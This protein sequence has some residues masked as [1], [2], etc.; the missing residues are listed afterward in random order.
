[1]LDFS[2]SP[3]YEP[4]ETVY[5]SSQVNPIVYAEWADDPVGFIQHLGYELTDEQLQIAYSVQ[6][7]RVT[8][9]QAAHGVGKTFLAALLLVWWVI[10]VRGEAI[11]TAP[12][13]RQVKELLWKEVNKAVINNGLPDENLGRVHYYLDESA[14]AIGFTANDNNSNAFQ[15]VHAARLLIIED[16][17]CGISNEI[18]DGAVSCATGAQNRI[19]R[20]GNPI[21]PNNAFHRACMLGH[22]RV[23]VWSHP[24]IAWAYEK[25]KEDGI[26]RLK[27]EVRAEIVNPDGTLV[28]QEDW[29]EE[30]PR[31]VVP[32]AISVFYVEE[33]A[34]PRGEKSAFWLGRV[35]GLFPEDASMA[36][37]P[38]SYWIAAR[39]RYDADPEYWEMLA[40]AQVKRSYGLDVGDVIDD[41]GGA[42]WDGPVL[43]WAAKKVV[44]GDRLD[45]HR[46]AHWIAPH[47]RKKLDTVY[48]DAIGIGAG[49]LAE[50]LRM[51][52]PTQGV[53]WSEAAKKPES[54]IN[55]K[56]EDFWRFRTR[57]VEGTAAIA[58]FDDPNLEA[59]AMR[60]FGGTYFEELANGKLRMELKRLTIERLGCSPNIADAIVLAS[61]G[62]TTS[63]KPLAASSNTLR[64][65]TPSRI[66]EGSPERVRNAQ[67]GKRSSALVRRLKGK[68]PR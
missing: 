56:I 6:H 41:H 5:E 11:S 35:E 27:P 34:R 8:N 30:L 43:R 54:F 67:P 47:V 9:V 46:A 63:L 36:I 68:T 25:S 38:P 2:V 13:A 1:M 45:V 17:A 42:R 14:R 58:P 37:I 3:I 16:E 32:G 31:D 19:L 4:L 53:K 44:Q 61:R 64:S 55:C 20:I 10:C 21:V 33:T 52:V 12:T 28:P 51:N 40:R 7:N 60:Q 22:I 18:D 24:N 23:P 29:P 57:L 49:T 66:R 59:E 26:H 62:L 65:T 39:A 50:L 48:V 15:G